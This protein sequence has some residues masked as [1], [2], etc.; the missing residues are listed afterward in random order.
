[1]LLTP[2]TPT[3][4]RAPIQVDTVDSQDN[5]YVKRLVICHV[6][7]QNRDVASANNVILPYCRKG[8]ML[9][10]K[11]GQSGSGTNC[12]TNK[13]RFRPFFERI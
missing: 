7:G 10:R 6:S 3:N 12:L 4:L 2:K 13:T 1:M 9:C 8:L 11:K 5:Y